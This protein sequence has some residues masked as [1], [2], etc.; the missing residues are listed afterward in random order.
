MISI[1]LREAAQ[2]VIDH[3]GKTPKKLGG[4]WTESGHRVVSALNIKNSRVDSNEHHYIS[5][6]MYEK[7]MPDPLRAGD[8]LV[9]SEAPLGEVAFLDRDVEWALGQRLF[10]LRA[11]PEILDGR[12]LYYLLKGGKPREEL[13]ARATGTTVLGIRQ[14]EL[15]RIQL[16]L[17]SLGEQRAIAATLGALDDKIESNRQLAERA[18]AVIDA[19][20]SQLLA[21]TSTEVLPLADLVEFNRLSVKPHSTDALRYIDIASVSPGQIDSV[22]ELTWDEAPSR[23]RRGVSDGDVIYSTVRPGN[24]AFAL[25]V[26][27]TPG[28]VASTG[29]A[30]MSPSVRLGSSMLT[31][32]VGA[33]EFAEYLESVAHGS[34][35]PAVGI[36]AMGSYPVVVPKEAVV[37][38]QFEADTMPLRRRVAQARAESERLAALR[39]TLLPELLSGRMRVPVEG[40]AA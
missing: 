5:T 34:A 19:S 26:D 30:V 33:P 38:E 31:S 13:F 27:P 25:I 10:A 28:S 12:Y 2:L 3:R 8:V 14:A 21:R 22:Q 35:Y 18:S 40:V 29:F 39:D 36:Q 20:A 23:A 4:D 24:R 16:E 6:E 32:V 15:V 1:P 17:P 37:A 7:W 9:T 11:R